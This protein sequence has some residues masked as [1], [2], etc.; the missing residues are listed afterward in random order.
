MPNVVSKRTLIGMAVKGCSETPDSRTKRCSKH[1]KDPQEDDDDVEDEAFSNLKCEVCKERTD[2]ACMLVCGD[3]YG[4]GCDFGY[5][6]Y[7]LNPPLQAIPPGEWFCQGCV[8]RPKTGSDAE[9]EDA[10]LK[11]GRTRS[12]TKAHADTSDMWTVEKIVDSR[13]DVEV[14]IRSPV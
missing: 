2:S 6:Y 5:H 13:T 7:C 3:D 12:Q 9:R 8:L 1:P 14:S 11:L 10:A 4:H